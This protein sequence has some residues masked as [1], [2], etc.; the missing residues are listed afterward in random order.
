[1]PEPKKPTPWKMGFATQQKATYIPPAKRI[2]TDFDW[3]EP[4]Y[5]WTRRH[6]A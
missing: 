6:N 1:M 5:W 3:Y 2:D 4:P